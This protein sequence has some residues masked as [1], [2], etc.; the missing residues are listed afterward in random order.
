GTDISVVMGR[1]FDVSGNPSGG[2]FYVS[3]KEVP[4]AKPLLARNP[5]AAWRGDT[6]AVVWESQNSGQLVDNNP[7]R[8]VAARLFTIGAPREPLRITNIKA[9]ASGVTTSWTGGD[10]P[11][12]VQGAIAVTGPWIDLVT[13]TDHTTTQPF[14]TPTGFFRIVDKTTKT[15]KQ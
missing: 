2:T 5:R 3:E 6:A 14:L 13:T 8:V 11:F 1:L 15:V 12:L 10:G 4:T 9:E 7:V